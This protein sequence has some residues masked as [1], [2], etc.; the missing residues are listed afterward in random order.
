M[1]KTQSPRSFQFGSPAPFFSDFVR[2]TPPGAP[3]WAETKEGSSLGGGV[4]A[5]QERWLA[6]GQGQWFGCIAAPSRVGNP[7]TNVSLHWNES[8]GYGLSK[9]Q[10]CKLVVHNV[11]L[12]ISKGLTSENKQ[13]KTFSLPPLPHSH[14]ILSQGIV[15]HWEKNRIKRMSP[16]KDSVNGP[17]T[18]LCPRR[19]S[20]L[21]YTRAAKPAG[22]AHVP[23]N[24]FIMTLLSSTFICWK[25][26]TESG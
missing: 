5:P 23:K 8:A 17:G 11:A 21:S 18:E 16:F 19:W 14:Q 3:V 12:T 6:P 24:M 25:I 9:P 22:K 2:E 13:N 10:V 7:G 1:I 26:R 15:R 20:C 4:P